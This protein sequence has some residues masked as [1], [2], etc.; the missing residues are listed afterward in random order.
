M[1]DLSSRLVFAFLG[2][3]AG[4]APGIPGTTAL[5]PNG[6]GALFRHLGPVEKPTAAF[7]HDRHSAI[8]HSQIEPWRQRNRLGRTALR[9]GERAPPSRYPDH[10]SAQQAGSPLWLGP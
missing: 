3:P 1:G 5:A 2:W 10:R 8:G 7:V 9:P 4:P 6:S